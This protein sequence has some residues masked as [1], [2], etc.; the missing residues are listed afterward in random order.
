MNSKKIFLYLSVMIMTGFGFFGLPVES[1]TIELKIPSI[2]SS[3]VKTST[4]KIQLPGWLT[5]QEALA[6]PYRRSVRRTARRTS[7]R[8]SHRNSGGYYGRPR[9]YGGAAVATGVAVGAVLAAGTIVNTLPPACS[10]VVV[11]GVVYQNCSGNY[12]A[13]NGNQWIIVA[14]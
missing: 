3:T 4:M 14:P 8:T 6:S 1:N 12:Y 10:S 9:Y 2:F 5:Q 7:R 13:P 11:N